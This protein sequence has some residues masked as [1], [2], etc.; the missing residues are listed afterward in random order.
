MCVISPYYN[1]NINVLERPRGKGELGNRC[2]LMILSKRQILS[3]YIFCRCV[4]DDGESNSCVDTCLTI[5]M[6]NL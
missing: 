5:Y 4:C 1:N 2:E 3:S 6:L